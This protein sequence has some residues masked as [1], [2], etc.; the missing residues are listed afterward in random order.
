MLRQAGRHR[1]QLLLQGARR[2]SLHALLEA[3]Q[4][5]VADLARSRAVRWSLD[6]DP[7]DC[8]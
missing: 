1:Y 2:G 4:P 3:L 8:Y 6:I 7:I 5:R